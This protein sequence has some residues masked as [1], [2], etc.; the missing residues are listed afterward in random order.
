[1]RMTQQ[2]RLARIDE[3]DMVADWLVD[4]D[5]RDLL[6]YHYSRTNEL[7]DLADEDE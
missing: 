5:A 2:E 6:Q 1:M 7:D 3:L 4:H